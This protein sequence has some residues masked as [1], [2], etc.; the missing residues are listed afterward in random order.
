M[1]DNDIYDKLAKVLRDVHE[2]FPADG[3]AKHQRLR[4]MLADHLPGAEREIRITLDVIDEGVVKVL[5]E[6]AASERGMQIDRL[7]SRL[8]TSRGIREDIARQI[9]QAF[10]Y[11]LS[12]GGLPSSLP[13]RSSQPRV[14]PV[15]PG[16]GDWVGVSE[17][18]NPPPPPPGGGGGALPPKDPS[19][20]EKLSKNKN[21][22]M[23]AAAVIVLAAYFFNSSNNPPGNEAAPSQDGGGMQEGGGNQQPIPGGG[24]GQDPGGQPPQGGGNQGQ[25]GNQPAPGG[26]GQGQG[27][28][29][30]PMGQGQGQSQGNP[31]P[32]GQGGNAPGGNQ[33]GPGTQQG[34]PQQQTT[35]A[36]WYDPFGQI[37]Q[38]QFTG[39]DFRGA[40]N[41]NGQT[42]G[43][44]GRVNP[45]DD[46]IQYQVVNG[47]G[48]AMWQGQGQFTDA[49]HVAFITTDAS[50]NVVGQ[51]QFHINH[52]PNQ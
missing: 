13:A 51:G 21:G 16:G 11:S 43:L 41:V 18:V 4:G 40:T 25:G 6:T 26:Q 31:Q 52:P 38:M 15:Q 1:A 32:M 14:P 24:G 30:P 22:V 7:V 8:D 50:G 12:L 9:I 36:L 45:Q 46:T 39:N 5:T 20:T 33:R 35:Q 19:L 42:A 3:F 47:A 49:Q 27:N 2:R 28:Q 34:S 29:P 17:V 23:I 48:Q 37:W 44:I 10:A